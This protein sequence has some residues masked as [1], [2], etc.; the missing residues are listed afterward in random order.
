[1]ATNGSRLCSSIL[2]ISSSNLEGCLAR[3]TISFSP[4]DTVKRLFSSLDQHQHQ[5]QDEEKSNQ[6]GEKSEAEEEKTENDEGDE[7][8]MNEETGEIGGPRGL[9]PTRFGDWERNGRCSDF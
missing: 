6:V 2:K 4:S 5:H 3:S 7:I 9:E 8:D 1:M